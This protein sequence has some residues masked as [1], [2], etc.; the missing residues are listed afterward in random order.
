MPSLDDLAEKLDEH[1]IPYKRREDSIWVQPVDESGFAVGLHQ[2][3]GSFTVYFEGWHEEFETAED[4]LNCFVF[5]DSPT[6]LG[7]RLV[8]AGDFRSNGHSSTE[9]MMGG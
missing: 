9:R 3:G 1:G 7:S 2:D 6:G 4:A 5:L 8:T